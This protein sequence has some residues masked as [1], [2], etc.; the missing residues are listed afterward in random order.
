MRR[1]ESLLSDTDEPDTTGA[2]QATNAVQSVQSAD[3]APPAQ[4]AP[5]S[6]DKTHPSPIEELLNTYGD[7]RSGPQRLA[8]W[9]AT[10][11]W[12][13]TTL[14]ALPAVYGVPPVAVRAHDLIGHGYNSWRFGR[15]ADS[16][17]RRQRDISNAE[18]ELNSARRIHPET[19]ARVNSA[20]ELAEAGD[21]MD[22]FNRMLNDRLAVSRASAVARAVDSALGISNNSPPYSERFHAYSGPISRARALGT[23]LTDRVDGFGI[24]RNYVDVLSL[25]GGDDPVVARNG[26]STRNVNDDFSGVHLDGASADTIRNVG[27]AQTIDIL[28]P[29]AVQNL[30]VRASSARNAAESAV[31]NDPTQRYDSRVDYAPEYINTVSELA[32]LRVHYPDAFDS[33]VRRMENSLFSAEKQTGRSIRELR[34]DPT[35]SVGSFTEMIKDVDAV[36]SV[37][38]N[39]NGDPGLGLI[40]PRSASALTDMP[41]VNDAVREIRSEYDRQA[42]VVHDVFDEMIEDARNRLAEAENRLAEAESAGLSQGSEASLRRRRAHIDQLR[43]NLESI[44]L[45]RDGRLMALEENA[46]LEPRRRA[47]SRAVDINSAQDSGLSERG[48]TATSY[49]IPYGSRYAINATRGSMQASIVRVAKMLGMSERDIDGLV[50]YDSVVNRLRQDIDTARTELRNFQRSGNG[51]PEYEVVRLQERIDRNERKIRDLVKKR[52]R[53]DRGIKRFAERLDR[54]LFGA[55]YGTGSRGAKLGKGFIPLGLAFGAPFVG[56]AFSSKPDPS[57]APQVQVPYFPPGFE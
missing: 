26:S 57:E 42:R 32:S 47:I 19:V 4:Q 5:S 31:T 45:E 9:T 33:Y 46:F 55:Y 39:I 2:S 7:T 56:R 23:I 14:P 54:S 50:D 35:S 44:E 41:S 48:P 38:G 34:A 37:L 22:T 3:P 18:T 52:D 11:P 20:R 51:V 27:R 36:S 40:Q 30:V 6:G 13:Q 8:D 25:L 15:A 49:D 10:H 43:N 53:F 12:W 16:I 21:S 17:V 29:T 1:L 24:D 28:N